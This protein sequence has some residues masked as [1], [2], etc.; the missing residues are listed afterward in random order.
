MNGFVNGLFIN[1]GNADGIPDSW[2]SGGATGYNLSETTLGVG[3]TWNFNCT[4]SLC[5]VWQ[6]VT[7]ELGKNIFTLVKWLLI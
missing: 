2:G 3:N 4:A 5:N 1:D 7:L 6:T